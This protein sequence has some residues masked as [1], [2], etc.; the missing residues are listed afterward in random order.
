MN[1]ANLLLLNTTEEQV[2]ALFLL[3]KQGGD[4]PTPLPWTN[5]TPPWQFVSKRRLTGCII[6]VT[7][8]THA[9]NTMTVP[10]KGRRSTGEHTQ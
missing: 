9:I 1:S 8:H 3:D 5:G 10:C 6:G 7:C 2:C 4:R